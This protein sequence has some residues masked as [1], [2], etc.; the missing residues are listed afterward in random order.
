MSTLPVILKF[1][2]QEGRVIC[3]H[4]HGRKK[5]TFHRRRGEHVSRSRTVVTCDVCNGEGTVAAAGP[6]PVKPVQVDAQWVQ[7][8]D[9]HF[10]VIR[11]NGVLYAVHALTDRGQIVEY[12]VLKSP[13][14]FYDIDTSNS[15]WT[16]DCPDNLSRRANQPF[17][18]K[19]CQAVRKL[20]AIPFVGQ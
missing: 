9:Q 11:V 2:Q 16:C 1:C 6:R 7:R 15:P 17:G 19:H 20:V 5:L 18:C 13:E 12:R 8:I 4:C 3:P 10:G 14:T